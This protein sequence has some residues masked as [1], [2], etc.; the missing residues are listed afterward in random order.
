[1]ATEK[2]LGK[3]LLRL[4]GAA[5]LSQSELAGLLQESGLNWYQ[6]TVGRT[7]NGQRP[8]RFSEAPYIAE[9][10]GVSLDVLAGLKPG[11]PAPTIAYARLIEIR[12]NRALL[13]EAEAEIL[14]GLGDHGSATLYRPRNHA[15]H[16]SS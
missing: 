14:E 15:R 12:R 16:A 11:E 8:L 3:I 5:G 4:R 6:T 1:M 9:A 7:E 10:L 2:Q 13:N